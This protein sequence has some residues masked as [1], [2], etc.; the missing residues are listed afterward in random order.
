MPQESQSTLTILSERNKT[1]GEFADNARFS[2]EM[3]RLFQSSDYW[4]GLSDVHKESLDMIALKISRILSGQAD[5]KDH[6]LDICGYSKL[7]ENACD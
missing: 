1:H 3:K 2:Q 4:E 7:G 5:F 6:W